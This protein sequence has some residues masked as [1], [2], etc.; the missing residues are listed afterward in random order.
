MTMKKLWLFLALAAPISG[1]S[2]PLGQPLVT[3]GQGAAAS[4]I[5]GGTVVTVTGTT[6]NVL[7]ST[8]CT[9]DANGP[10]GS[11][12]TFNGSPSG[13]VTA[14]VAIAKYASHCV[15]NNTG[16]TLILTGGVGATVSIQPGAGTGTSSPTC[17][18][19]PDGINL[20]N[21]G[22][23]SEGTLIPSP[24]LAATVAVCAASPS[25]NIAAYPNYAGTDAP[26]FIPSAN[27]SI[28]D[29]RNGSM[30]KFFNNWPTTDNTGNLPAEARGDV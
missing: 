27:I 22:A 12:L 9:I 6:C 17:V 25:C 1:Q 13:T 11:G 2:L 3:T 26:P 20:V 21:S 23:P 16:Q 28:T 24:T 7:T 18:Y 10:Y 30:A 5:Q 29:Y 19:S 4:A 8:G 15:A 14:T